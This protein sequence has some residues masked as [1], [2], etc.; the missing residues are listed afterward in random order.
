VEKREKVKSKSLPRI[1]PGSKDSQIRMLSITPHSL[2]LK[3][4]DRV[5]EHTEKCKKDGAM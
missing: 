2:I 4:D 5:Y 1:E 3:G